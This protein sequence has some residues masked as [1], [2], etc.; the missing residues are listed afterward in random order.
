MSD[1]DAPDGPVLVILDEPGTPRFHMRIMCP[2]CEAVL[3]E[4][5][6]DVREADADRAGDEAI[7]D[8]TV[9]LAHRCRGN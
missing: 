3:M 5:A 9:A 4:R 1:A 2:R 7:A 6:Y 8:A